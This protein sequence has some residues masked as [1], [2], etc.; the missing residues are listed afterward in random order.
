MIQRS[1]ARPLPAS[2]AR[3]GLA[4][5]LAG[6]L[7]ADLLALGERQLEAGAR[8]RGPLGAARAQAHLDPLPLAVV[9][10][11]VLEGLGVEVGAEPV[12]QHAQDV[13]VELGR[14]ARRVVVGGVEARRVLHEVDA[15]QEARRR[16]ASTRGRA[17]EERGQLVGVQVADRAGEE[18]QQPSAA[19]AERLEVV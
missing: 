2:R 13:A 1:S 12:V 7:G 9:E 11:A 17:A 3:E 14:D 4:R 8:A 5:V 6:Q 16:G 18:Q 15:D 19:R 10:G